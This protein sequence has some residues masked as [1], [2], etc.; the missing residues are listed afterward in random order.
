VAKSAKKARLSRRVLKNTIIAVIVISCCLALYGLSRLWLNYLWYKSLGQQAVFVGRIVS[1]AVTMLACGVV[2]FIIIWGTV[3]LIGRLARVDKGPLS[4]ASWVALLMAVISGIS[5]SR[6]WITFRLAVAGSSF[7]VR[8]PLF[9]KDVGFFVFTIP[10]LNVIYSW[11]IG[12]MVLATTLVLLALIIPQQSDIREAWKKQRWDMKM[13][14]S[15]LG[16]LYII[17]AGVGGFYLALY[18][19]AYSPKGMITGASYADARVQVPLFITL[20]ITGLLLAIILVVTARSHRIKLPFWSTIVWVVLIVLGVNVAPRIVQAYV[21]A[22]NEATLEHPYIADNIK[23]TRAAFAL[24]SVETTSYPARAAILKGNRVQ[25]VQQLGDVC[26]WGDSA[27]SQTASQTFNQLQ[28]IRPYYQLSALMTDRYTVSANDTQQQVL[29][30][31]R[32]INTSKLPTKKN[33]WVN[34][35]LV[36]T[37]GYGSTI[38]AVSAADQGVPQFV[39]GGVP[40]TASSEATA[41]VFNSLV[42]AQQRLYF[43]PGMTDYIITNTK[44]NEFDYPLIDGKSAIDRGTDVI[45]VKFGGTLRRIAWAINYGS[46]SLLFSSYPQPDSIVVSNRDIVSRAQAIAPWFS[47]DAKPSSTIVDG[48]TYWVLDG[49]TSSTTFP[50]SQPLSSG[51]DTGANYLRASVK[52]VVDAHTGAIK[53]YAVGNDPI[54]DAWAKIFP[55]VITP[56]SQIP[57]ALAEHFLYPKRAF[58]AQMQ[59]YMTYHITDPMTFYDQEDLWQ[60]SKGANGA[61]SRSAYLMMALSEDPAKLRIHMMQVFS[62]VGT[63]NLS[64]IMTVGCDPDNYGQFMVYQLPKGQAVLSAAQVSAQINQ[65]PTIAPQIALWSKSG[66]NVIMG[67]M[68]ILPVANSIVYVQPVFLKAQKNAVTQL[69][70]VIVVNNGKAVMGLDIKDAL[71]KLFAQ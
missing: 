23:M 15:I 40:P 25:A 1:Q 17:I 27:S 48:R 22:P 13:A 18:R 37:H 30:A 56:Q 32:L 67:S 6:N 63:P 60:V 12:L 29:I 61:A 10:A 33:N 54:R 49:Y 64:G 16:A 24:D 41:T 62:P 46:S 38:G 52:V 55:A 7:G 26:L 50:Y 8:D 36:Y 68:S 3:N 14:A 4:I 28:Q 5:M 53:F 43:G 9:N 31:S 19:L 71:N 11:L 58:D 35:H 65:D 57:P 45:G 44:L 39:L 70:R 51:I 69:A 2:A 47:Y 20:M 66:S 21:V 42:L 59:M 34:T